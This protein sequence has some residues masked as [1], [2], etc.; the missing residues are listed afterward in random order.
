M[1]GG[2]VAALGAAGMC[3][4]AGTAILLARAGASVPLRATAA[5]TGLAWS[6]VTAS[7][8]SVSWLPVPLVVTA[9][10]VPLVLADLRHR[11]L[12]DAL[13]LPAYP[14]IVAVVPDPWTALAAAAVFG[15]LHLLVHVIAPRAMGAGDV[16]LA[17]A[18]GAALGSV[19]W[20]AL[21]VATVVAA[22]ITALL[23]LT[24]RWTEGVPHGPGLLTGAAALAILHVPP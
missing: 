24:G 20:F 19:G 3:V 11:R 22:F 6:V 1:N 15:G 13:T 5:G 18:L 23:G 9:L 12:P 7:V 2:L 17:G 8:T 10:A 4:G 16:K 14:L 21:P